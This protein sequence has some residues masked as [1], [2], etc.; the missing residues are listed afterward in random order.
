MLI[1][2]FQSQSDSENFQW[3]LDG[4]V[5]KCNKKTTHVNLYNQLL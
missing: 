3:L 4:P 1:K 5:T 2:L